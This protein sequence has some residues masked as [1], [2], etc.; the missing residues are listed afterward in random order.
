VDGV[1]KIRQIRVATP[2]DG[3]AFVQKVG[4][5]QYSS[6]YYSAFL[7]PT[8]RMLSANA[9]EW[10]GRSKLF[11]NVVDAASSVRTRYSLEGNVSAFYADLTNHNSPRAIVEA[12]FFLLKDGDAGPQILFVQSYSTSAPITGNG[13]AGMVEAWNHACRTMLEELTGDLRRSMPALWA[14]NR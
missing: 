12:Q 1:L 5:D 6:D 13:P 11:A 10:L 8:D 9:C 3:S 7:M 4:P 2:Y 14:S